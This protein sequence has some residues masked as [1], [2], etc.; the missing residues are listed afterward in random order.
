[1]LDVDLFQMAL[2]LETR[3]FVDRTE[4]DAEAKRLDLYLE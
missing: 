4:F 3:W 2:G 1:M